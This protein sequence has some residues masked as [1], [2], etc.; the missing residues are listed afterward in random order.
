MDIAREITNHLEWMEKIVAVL[1]SD[2]VS[3]T[4]LAVI[5]QHDQ[6]ALGKWLGSDQ[7]MRFAGLPAYA[8][9]EAS[10]AAFHAQ[11][12]K[13]ITA[14]RED[15]AAAAM[16]SQAEFVRLSKLVVGNLLLLQ[17]HQRASDQE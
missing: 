13:L 11:A 4:D 14:I 9:L 6:C 8:E 3:D 1:G 15:H 16:A 5:T 2:Q 17:E 7:S 10:H 12:G